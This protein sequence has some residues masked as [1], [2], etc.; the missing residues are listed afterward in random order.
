MGLAALM[1]VSFYTNRQP[2][3]FTS[4][5]PAQCVAGATVKWGT[6]GLM[7]HDSV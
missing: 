2:I 7:I 4:Q 5:F 3:K 6:F 1:V